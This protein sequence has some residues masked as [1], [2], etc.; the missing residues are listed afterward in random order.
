M[1]AMHITILFLSTV[2]NVIWTS[3]HLFRKFYQILREIVRKNLVKTIEIG[4]AQ[5]SFAAEAELRC[6]AAKVTKFLI[7]FPV[8]TKHISVWI[9]MVSFFHDSSFWNQWIVRWNFTQ[10][11]QRWLLFKLSYFFQWRVNMLVGKLQKL[12]FIP[13]AFRTTCV[14]K[15]LQLRPLWTFTFQS[16]FKH[17][18]ISFNLSSKCKCE[19]NSFGYSTLSAQHIPSYFEASFWLNVSVSTMREELI[20]WVVL[21]TSLVGVGAFN[22]TGKKVVFVVMPGEGT[23]PCESRARCKKWCSKRRSSVTCRGCLKYHAFCGVPK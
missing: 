22:L 7:M 5:D 4:S 3:K 12:F 15:M 2:F 18:T 8:W 10:N 14:N 23:E 20:C 21:A 9:C 11:V 6:V 16:H 19:Q 13:V 17:S 1:A